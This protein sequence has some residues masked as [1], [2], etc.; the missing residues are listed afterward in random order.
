MNEYLLTIITIKNILKVYLV[1]L[2]FVIFYY[3]IS[4]FLIIID[5]KETLKFSCSKKS[6]WPAEKFID[7]W[8]IEINRI[9]QSESRIAHKNLYF[10]LIF[11]YITIYISIV[12]TLIFF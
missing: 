11:I 7:N 2:I 4:W 6:S 1:I 9:R 8:L 12:L 3:F 5:S 10:R